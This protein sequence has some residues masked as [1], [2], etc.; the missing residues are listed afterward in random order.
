MTGLKTE[1][2]I[3]AGPRVLAVS[4]CGDVTGLARKVEAAVRREASAV[5]SFGVAGGLAPELAPG[6]KLVA[7]SVIAQDGARYFGDPAWSQRLS[8]A[9]GGAAIA[10]IS[11]VDL[12]VAG[13]AE[14]RAL[15]RKTG[16][17]AADTESHVA[18]RVAAAHNLPFAAFRVV[19]DPAH[20]QLPH[21]A[22]LAI[23]A[24]G[25]IAFGA[26]AGSLLRDPRQVPQLMRTANDARAAFVALFR[27]RQMLASALGFT[28]FGEL[29]LDVPAEE[30]LGGPLRV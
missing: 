3:A 23:R 20:R 27:G 9:L 10:D 5:I 13:P 21:A 18:A 28:N 22:L 15:H 19:A 8:C 6:T 25:S 11:G 2:R 17:L 16:A 24:D 1:A 12:P 7:R 30:I 26:I 4:G 14:R 29:L